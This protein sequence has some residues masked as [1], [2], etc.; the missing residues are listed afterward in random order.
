MSSRR[1]RRYE[2]WLDA[3][4]LLMQRGFSLAQAERASGLSKGSLSRLLSGRR[5]RGLRV[6]T[7]KRLAAGTRIPFR[8]LMN[9]LEVSIAY[10]LERRQGMLDANP[11]ASRPSCC[12][13]QPLSVR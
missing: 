6:E 2:P 8:P 1:S 3:R 12:S 5:G 4:G 9:A 11:P 13:C 7:V 10:A